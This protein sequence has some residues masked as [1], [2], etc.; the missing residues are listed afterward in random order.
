MNRI[1][2]LI[3]EPIVLRAFPSGRIF[4]KFK[5]VALRHVA[6]AKKGK[7]NSSNPDKG[8]S[9]GHTTLFNH[10]LDSEM[11]ESELSDERLAKEA[12]VLLG[13]G[14]ASTARTI[15]Y[16]SYYILAYPHIGAKL[17]QELREVMASYPRQVPCLTELERL[18]YLQALIKEGL[19]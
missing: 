5:K 8:G 2:G 16:I 15:T 3:P 17:Q 1:V 18:P 7:S 13:G 12:Q 14:T 9:H 6:M 4:D 10:I 11:P 19:R